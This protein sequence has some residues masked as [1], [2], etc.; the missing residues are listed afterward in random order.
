MELYPPVVGY[1]AEPGYPPEATT[2]S[3]ESSTDETFTWTATVSPGTP[4]WLEVTPLG[5]N[6][7]GQMTVT[8]DP[9]GLSYGTY[10]AS[11]R[12]V[13]GSPE[14]EDHDQTVAVTLYV[15]E[16]IYSTYLPL[17]GR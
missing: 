12:V 11:I 16:Q 8:L 17:V 13:A 14:I 4:A 2:V 10:E 15:V 1:M 6:S 5:G 3:V 9:A 7:G